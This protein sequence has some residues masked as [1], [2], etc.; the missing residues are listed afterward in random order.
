M[1][2][3]Y[4]AE[5]HS[6]LFNAAI[7]QFPHSWAKALAA[8]GFDPDEQKTPRGR[9]DRQQAAD[10]VRNRAAKGKSLL[11]RAAPRDLLGFI[12]RRLGVTWPDFLES[13]G[14]AYPGIRKRRDW[15]KVKLLEEIRRWGAEGHRLNYK[16]VALEY[17][18][19]I[20]QARK[21]FGSWDRARAAAR[22]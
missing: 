13:L 2:A 7:K 6:T 4:V 12:H 17:Q 15:S 10:W 21:F 19:L 5:H 22:V 16:A 9:W 1:A 3:Q 14:V 8:A 11:A 18:A 20:H